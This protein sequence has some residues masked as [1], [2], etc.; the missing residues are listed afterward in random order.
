MTV[1]AVP[2]DLCTGCGACYNTCPVSAIKMEYNEEGFFAPVIDD[3][4]CINCGLCEKICPALHPVYKNNERPSAYAVWADDGLRKA[5]SSGGVFSVLADYVL[6]KGGYVCGAA[7]DENLNLNHIIIDSKKMLPSL[8]GSKYLQSNS[9]DSF[10]QIKHLLQ[11]DKYVLFCG[12]PCQVA[13]LNNYLGNNNYEKLITADLLCHGGVAPL[14]FQRYLKECFPNKEIEDYK[15]RDKKYGWVA[16]VNVYYKNKTEQ[17]SDRDSDL[18]FRAF[19]NCYSTRKSCG[20]CQFAKLPRQADF[21]L[22]DFWGCKAYNP[23]YDDG[24]GTSLVFANNKKAEQLLSKLKNK[25]TLLDKIDLDYIINKTGQP[26]SHPFKNT[27]F[28]HD[29]FFF[30]LKHGS[31]EKAVT[32]CEKGKFDVALV[33]VWYGWNYGSVLTNYAL[34]NY[35]RNMGLLV[36]MVEKPCQKVG[37]NDIELN[38]SLHSRAFAIKHYGTNISRPRMPEEMWQL[39]RF[40]DIF[41]TGSD[42]LWHYNIESYTKGAFLLNFVDD[43]HKKIAYST[44]FGHD[45]DFTPKDKLR[46]RISLFKK[47]DHISVRE[48]SGV[49]ILKKYGVK[50]VKVLDPVFLA[51]KKLFENLAKEAEVEE[52]EKFITAYI[53]DPTEEKTNAIKKIAKELGMPVKAMI[54]GMPSRYEENKQKIGLEIIEK[55]TVEQWVYYFKNASFIITDSY[56]G[57][58][59]S[60]I[61][62]KNFVAFGNKIRGLTRFNTIF[63]IIGYKE[64]LIT[65]PAK[66]LSSALIKKDINYK[67]INQRLE[68]HIKYSENWLKNAIYSDKVINELPVYRILD[69]KTAKEIK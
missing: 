46:E 4:I 20:T 16:S 38:P 58:C 21:T 11:Q 56:H 5:S 64:R 19:N 32:Y 62:E 65:D 50:S 40:A 13:G 29:R 22:G 52:K 61:F 23:A 49:D 18:Y 28:M 8:R 41:M 57:T 53:L 35:L 44:S 10:K 15:F 54:D 17:H 7:Y 33:G 43:S 27:T 68:P 60:V 51:D 48:D 39:N 66:Q 34:Y 67:I 45:T 1:N 69:A 55:P 12:V 36:L 6:G 9:Q 25:F 3:K 30:Y 24:K 14:A 59:F 31:F 26:L 42:Q 37:S 2:Y 47:F 63:D